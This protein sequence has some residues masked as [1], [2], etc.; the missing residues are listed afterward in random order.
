M[1]L[2]TTQT[3]LTSN[4]MTPNTLQIP[5]NTSLPMGKMLENS[6]TYRSRDVY[7]M[8]FHWSKETALPNEKLRFIFDREF[9]NE[10]LLVEFIFRS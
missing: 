4:K 8:R 1:I 6:M 7:M 2:I 3:E 9:E 10:I 5:E